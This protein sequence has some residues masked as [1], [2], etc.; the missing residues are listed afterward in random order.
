MMG[1]VWEWCSDW[2]GDYP[3]GSVT[4]PTGPSSGSLRVLRG[5]SWYLG[6]RDA[7]SANRLRGDPGYRHF[8]L[9]FRPALSSVR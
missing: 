6:A 9:G 8:N 7:R 1:N 4:D 5:G 2:R 3:T